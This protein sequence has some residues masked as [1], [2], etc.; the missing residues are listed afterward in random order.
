MPKQTITGEYANK[1][2][3]VVISSKIRVGHGVGPTVL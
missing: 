2:M 3:L 1:I